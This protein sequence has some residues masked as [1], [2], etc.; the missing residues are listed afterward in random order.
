[1]PSVRDVAQ[2][3]LSQLGPMT[4]MKLQ[5]LAYYSRAWSVVRDDDV[6]FP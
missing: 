2:Y 4:T 3:I 1:M 6:I 5:K